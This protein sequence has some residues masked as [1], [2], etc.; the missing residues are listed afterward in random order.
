M[1]N[2][3]LSDSRKMACVHLIM[4]INGQCTYN[5]AHMN[6]SQIQMST[7]HKC[8]L[9]MTVNHLW[10]DRIEVYVIISHHTEYL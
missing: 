10:K 2:L 3:F 4:H 9:S 5:Y 6:Y 1:A 8:K 7:F